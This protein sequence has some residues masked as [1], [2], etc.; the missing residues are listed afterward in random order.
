MHDPRT[1]CGARVRGVWVACPAA[2][3]QL[4]A[5]RPPRGQTREN[6]AKTPS[7]PRNLVH[8]WNDTVYCDVRTIDRY[9]QNDRFLFRTARTHPPENSRKLFVSFSTRSVFFPPRDFSRD[10]LLDD[11]YT[12]RYPLMLHYT[13]KISYTWSGTEQHKRRLRVIYAPRIR[14]YI[15]VM[16]C[17]SRTA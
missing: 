7:G 4:P 13:Y 16:F 1:V 10:D 12:V 14:Y 2:I 11:S 15:V 3:A 9:A 5:N 6:E 8:F 17:S